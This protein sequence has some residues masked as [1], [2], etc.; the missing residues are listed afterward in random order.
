MLAIVFPP[1]RPLESWGGGKLSGGENFRVGRYTLAG[2]GIPRR[3]D[4]YPFL[5]HCGSSSE[6]THHE[7]YLVRIFAWHQVDVSR[8]F[9]LDIKSIYSHT[10]RL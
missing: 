4:K 2:T 7:R 3:K 9:L 6:H 10:T 5:S 8:N 1:L